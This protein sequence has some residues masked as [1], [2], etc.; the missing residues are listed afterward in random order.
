[1]GAQTNRGLG[2]PDIRIRAYLTDLF[3]FE[4][5]EYD[6]KLDKFS[7][8]KTL[9]LK[10]DADEAEVLAHFC[11]GML[12]I[13]GYLLVAIFTVLVSFSGKYP[14]HFVTGVLV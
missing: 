4:F 2:F 3:T 6:P 9:E 11:E 14:V 13:H 7:K 5:I 8:I 1:M 12:L 10:K